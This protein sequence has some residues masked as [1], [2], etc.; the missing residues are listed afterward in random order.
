V[1]T[2]TD[3]TFRSGN[4]DC[5]AW[6]YRPDGDATGAAIVL[7]H[8]FGG[9]RDARL[10]AFAERFAG[11]GLTALVFDYRHFG[12]SG[13][14]PRQLL[15]IGLQLDDWRAAIAYARGLDDVDPDRVAI[16]G[17]SFSGGHVAA[18]A[19]ED[20]R[21]AAA[22]SQAPFADGM[23][24]LP[25]LGVVNALK[26][27]GHGLRDQIGAL[28]GRPPHTIGIVGPPGSSAVMSTPDAEPGYRALFDDPDAQF[29][30]E[31]AARIALRIGTY[32]PGRRAA[33]IACPWLV[34][35]CDREQIAPT[36]PALAAAARAPRGEAVRY[37]LG[38]F[39]IYVGAP[40]ERAVSDQIA[41]LSRHGLARA[42]STESAATAS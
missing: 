36:G 21:L 41:F 1:A 13:G 28:A 9:T 12:A 30:N 26:M 6:L 40:F 2:R 31:V 32:R 33:R 11:A 14:E 34:Q 4:A 39:D 15:D 10:W 7:A 22:I 20:H 18:I 42:A 38:H 37:D 25:F 35:V 17:S 19:A 3:V 8:G 27:T 23:A 24:N 29:V 16:W 5:A